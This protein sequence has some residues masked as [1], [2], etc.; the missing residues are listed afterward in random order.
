MRG[1]P[2]GVRDILSG[3]ELPQTGAGAACSER[4]ETPTPNVPLACNLYFPRPVAIVYGSGTHDP[5][6]L[7]GEHGGGAAA[8]D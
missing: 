6:L 1:V 7:R 5:C 4:G 8:Q 2:G 3:L